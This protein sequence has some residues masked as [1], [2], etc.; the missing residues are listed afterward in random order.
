MGGATIL[1]T[2]HNPLITRTG[3]RK[4]DTETLALNGSILGR[5][6]APGKVSAWGRDARAET[7]AKSQVIAEIGLETRK[8]GALGLGLGALTCGYRFV[9]YPISSG[10]DGI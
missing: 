2:R 4:R 3:R 7:Q 8:A 10:G 6:T 1:I 5:W 9:R